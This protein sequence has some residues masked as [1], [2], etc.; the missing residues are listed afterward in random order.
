MI[1]L[2]YNA[3]APL[4][5]EALEAV[6]EA[7]RCCGNP[8]SQHGA[9][10]AARRRVEAAHDAVRDLVGAPDGRVV[11]T[12]SGT[13]ADNLALDGIAR[14]RRE[15]AGT[16]TV[17]ISAIEHP[18][19]QAAADRLTRTGFEIRRVSV[20]RDGR[21]DLAALE[22]AVDADVAL[23]SVMLANNETGVLQP[24]ADVARH[25][26]QHGVP[27][28]TDAVQAAGKIRVSMDELGVDALS[29]SAHKLGGPRG[30]GAL[31]LRPGMQLE[32]LWHGGGQQDGLRSG[33]PAVPLAAGLAAAA[34]A[35]RRDL[36]QTAT[37]ASMRDELENGIYALPDAVPLGA[38]AARLPNT[39]LVAFRNVQ[40]NLLVDRLSDAGV[41][42]SGGA[43]CHADRVEAS[44]VLLAMGVAAELAIGAVRLSLGS[45]TTP[46]DVARAVEKVR[47]AVEAVRFGI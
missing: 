4:R 43:A 38:A 26:R 12:A 47:A 36:D 22:K 39:A 35:A 42:V 6:G 44:P 46:S 28:H 30:I 2:D 21:L 40:S 17:V 45:G 1:F 18:A 32:P 29:L 15:Q 8:A 41:M 25:A 24:V 13:E 20:G 34:R 37:L 16:T 14:R 7:V 10:R 27:V 3:T 19:I 9:G 11:L 5:L 33:T 23:V 31:V